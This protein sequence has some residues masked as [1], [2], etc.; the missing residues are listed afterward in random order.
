VEL[1]H[2]HQNIS[3]IKRRSTLFTILHSFLN[4]CK[5]P[6][7]EGYPILVINGK[8]CPHW[9]VLPPTFLQF[10]KTL[11]Q[12]HEVCFA[13]PPPPS[14]SLPIPTQLTPFNYHHSFDPIRASPNA[15]YKTIAPARY[16]EGCRAP[17]TSPED[18]FIT[19]CGTA[20][21]SQRTSQQSLCKYNTCPSRH[22][23]LLCHIPHLP[24][25]PSTETQ[26]DADGMLATAI[27]TYA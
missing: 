3:Y 10:Q 2:G 5:C 26:G 13:P 14:P 24:V 1:S 15:G 21:E 20:H 7:R 17:M 27:A 18:C 23:L 25:L 22:M 11:F 9:T 16:V 12:K 8:G 4:M 6:R 19:S